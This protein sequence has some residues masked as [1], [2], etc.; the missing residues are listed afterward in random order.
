[1]A[2]P[3]SK[4]TAIFD[5]PFSIPGFDESFPAGEYDLE[6]EISAPPDHQNPERWKASVLVRLHSRESHPG[7]ARSLTVPLAV[8]DH[9]LARDKQ[10]GRSLVDFFVEEMLADPMVQ[11]VM[12]ADRV[13]DAEIRSIYSR[14]RQSSP[15]VIE[16]AQGRTRAQLLRAAQYRTA[17]QV[18]ENE[19]MP[20]RHR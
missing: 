10:T 7:L 15:S 14:D 17:V 2:G 8:L 6:T 12:H 5:R 13:T 16:A 19:G 20:T 18:A 1:M 11:L 3:F 4:T 9:A